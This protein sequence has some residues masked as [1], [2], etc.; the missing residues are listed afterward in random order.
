VSNAGS[1]VTA[2]T[3]TEV[4]LNGSASSDAD[5]DALSFAWTLV[6]KPDGSKVS[7]TGITTATPTFT[8]DVSG[9]YEASLVVSDGKQSSEPATVTITVS[10]DVSVGFDS[11]PSPFPP[12]MPS[13][14]FAATQTTSLG[15]EIT[16]KSGGPRLLDSIDVAM[17]SWACE[18]GNWTSGCVT[19]PGSSFEHP[20]TI[21]IFDANGTELATKTQD[22]VIPYRPTPAPALECTSAT[23]WKAEDGNCYNGKA[24]PIT[25]DLRSLG[26]TVQDTFRYAVS[27]NT[28]NY[29]TPPLGTPG[30]YDSLNV[31]VYD[32]SVVAPTVGSDTDGGTGTLIRNG[33]PVAEGYG[34]MAQVH[35][36]TP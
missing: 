9:T 3:G 35:V 21:T 11:M 30:G 34:I 1:A 24:F 16:L 36:T 31:G 18:S 6:S 15:E 19:T 4:T 5:G 25:F 20:I 8:P 17:S 10:P 14:A 33:T 26:V 27:F 12:N 2:K 13:Y 7:L 29:G 28:A 22:F 23:Q 32:S